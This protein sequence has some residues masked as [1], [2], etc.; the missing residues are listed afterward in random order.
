MCTKKWENLKEFRRKFNLRRC[1]DFFHR[2]WGNNV[3][4]KYPE[5]YVKIKENDKAV[6]KTG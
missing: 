3:L 1:K 5:N 6:R 2:P 4:L